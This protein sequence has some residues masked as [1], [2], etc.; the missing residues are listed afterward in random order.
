[1]LTFFHNCSIHLFF[2]ITT[3]MAVKTHADDMQVSLAGTW[4]FQLD[5]KNIGVTEKWFSKNLEDVVQLPGTT[6]TNHKGNKNDDR[7]TD[8]LTR[9]WS[10]IG[11][12]WYQRE[13]TVPESWNGKRLTLFFERTKNTRVW[14]NDTLVGRHDSL[15]A[16]QVFDVT[17]AMKPGKHTITVL[18]DNAKLPPVG[19]SHA[20]DERTQTNWNGIVGRM[21][22][23]ATDPVWIDEVQIYPDVANKTA[24][25]RAT[26]GNITGKPAKG[27]ITVSS[28]STNTA[29]PV[30]FKTQVTDIEAAEKKTTIEFT[31]SPGPD[32]PLWDEFNPAL[33]SLALKLET[34]SGDS[35][36]LDNRI[37]RFG[38]RNFTREGDRLLLNGRPVFLRGRIDCANYPLTGYAPMDKSE[39]LRLM[40]IHKDWGINHIRYH[41]WCP[42]AAAFD[43]ADETGILLQPELPNKRS[44]FNA[45]DNADAAFHNIDFMEVETTESNVSL[46]EYAKREG[47]LIF[48][49]F[50]NS[51]SFVLFTLGNELGRNEG[52]FEMVAHYQKIDPRRLHAQGSNNMHWEPSFAEGDDFWVIG[53]LNN[54]DKAL[55]GSFAFQDFPNPHIENRSPSTIV[56]YSFSIEGVSVPLI[57][58]ETGQFQVSPDFREIEKFTGV[59]E[60]RN[61]Q[62]FRDRL[63]AAGMIGQAHDFFKASG[64]LAVICYREDI[65]AALR[66]RGFGGFQLLD[67]QDFPGQGTALIGLLNVF[68]ESKGLIDPSHW[69]EF[70]NETVPLFRMGKYVWTNDESLTGKV[71]IAHYGPV[72][73]ENAVVTANL[74]DGNDKS[75]SM[76]KLPALKLPTG[77]VTDIGDFNVDLTGLGLTVPQQLTLEL[78]IEGTTFRNRYSVWIFPKEIDNTAPENVMVTR[79]YSDAAT[80]KHL[81]MGGKVLLMPDLGKLPHSV[82]G[83]FQTEFW[84]PMFAQSARKRK[85]LEPP[86]TLGFV[87]DPAHPALAKF[88]TD[89]HS[90]WQW[91]HLVKNSRPIIYDGSPESFRPIVQVIDNFDRNQKLGLIAETKVGKGSMLICSIDLLAHQEKPESRQLLHSLLCY[92]D[93]PDF[94]PKIELKAPL[95]EKLLVK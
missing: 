51:P 25:V 22:L 71:Q 76:V 34:S 54:E 64:A 12:A 35:A 4:R 47:G 53:K 49:H 75:L 45:P 24:K 94:S 40:R 41:S 59:L 43:A 78:T 92:L 20:V 52:M 39:W 42:P 89:F 82:A 13:V 21:E 8:R 9:V 58:H 33:I 68:M 15:S 5:S 80:Q 57:G 74:I 90:D 3:L 31:Y 66:T 30:K 28:E 65:E 83:Q 2:L 86:G 6:D 14:V 7:P 87:C 17:Q 91:W 69:R 67:L 11:P 46:Y 88:P 55:R 81:A 85:T 63:K 50:G 60:A 61:Y 77:D 73:I 95:L 26:I 1:M 10:W 32:V 18:I 84:S 16:P 44:A 70:C 19:P 93:S 36:F 37:V 27:K 72:A 38:M 56:D 23:H 62:I 29:R 79:N 48:R